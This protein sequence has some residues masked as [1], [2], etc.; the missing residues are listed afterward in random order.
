MAYPAVAPQPQQK[1][2][3]LA[4]TAFVLA[5]L[6]FL[7]LI[8]LIGSVLGVVALIRHRPDRGG[9]GLAIA[10]IPTGLVVTLMLQ[11]MI[12]AI[13]IPSF[14]KYLRKAKAS[15]ASQQLSR[16]R[17][18]LLEYAS[19]ERQLAD[20]RRVRVF[21][22]GLTDWTPKTRCCEQ[23]NG[24]CPADPVA[25]ASGPWK[26]LGLDPTDG[27]HHY[28]QWRYRSNGLQAIVEARGDLDCDGDYSFYRVQGKIADGNVEVTRPLVQS[29]LE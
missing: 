23:P 15:E 9:R 8:P 10:A 22:I 27:R 17:L 14:V 4:I 13:A 2:S 6:F 5:L 29:P 28:Y 18:Q 26:E 16:V 7:P 24:K 19:T 1:T 21:P 25:F 11:G 20:G 12:A 3:G